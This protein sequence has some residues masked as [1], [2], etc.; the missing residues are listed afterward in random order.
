MFPFT[1]FILRSAFKE[2]FSSID[3]WHNEY[4]V[5]NVESIFKKPI[6]GSERKNLYSILNIQESYDKLYSQI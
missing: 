3:I 2:Y 5:Q 4:T 6:S 1:F